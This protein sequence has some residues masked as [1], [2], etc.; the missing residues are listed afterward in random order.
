MQTKQ[1]SKII[2]QI[3]NKFMLSKLDNGKKFNK[4]YKEPL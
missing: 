4:E 1:N 2:L 3:K